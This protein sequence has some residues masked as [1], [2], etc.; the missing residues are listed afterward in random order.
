VFPSEARNCTVHAS[1]SLLHLST[2]RMQCPSTWGEKIS[3]SEQ[4]HLEAARNNDTNNKG[5]GGPHEDFGPSAARGGGRTAPE[6]GTSTPRV[7]AAS[8]M[9]PAA[10]SQARLQTLKSTAVVGQTQH[11]ARAT[12]GSMRRPALATPSPRAAGGEKLSAGHDS[13]H[14]TTSALGRRPIPRCF[15]FS[16]PPRVPGIAEYIPSLA[17]THSCNA[18]GSFK[19]RKQVCPSLCPQ[20]R[21]GQT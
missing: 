17:K 20:Q 12:A 21:E 14:P 18:D 15:G 4:C 7:V 16:L 11:S 19:R 2:P 5:G 3:R 10:L 6:V 8:G 9:K 1:R 13:K